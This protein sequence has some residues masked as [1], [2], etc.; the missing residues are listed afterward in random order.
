MLRSLE[1]LE[2]LDLSVGDASVHFESSDRPG[3]SFRLVGR[4]VLCDGRLSVHSGRSKGRLGVIVG[5]RLP[6]PVR[7]LRK[8]SGGSYARNTEVLGIL[9]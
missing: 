5:G 9:L 6:C 7:F 3:P 2:A 4:G 1:L 8:Y